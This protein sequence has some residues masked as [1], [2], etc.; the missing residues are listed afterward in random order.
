[1]I[2]DSVIDWQELSALYEQAEGLDESGREAFLAPLRAQK[3]RLLGQLE[4]MLQAR[5]RIATSTFLESL[6]RLEPAPEPAPSDLGEGSRVG[7]YRLIRP[8]GSGGMAEVWLA[9]RAD[10]AFDRQVAIKLLF[11]Q[12]TRSQREGFVARFER[13]RDILASLQ[14]PHIAGLHDAGVTSSGQPWLALE[15]VQGERITDWCDARRLDVRARIEL[16]MQVLDAVAYA[17]ANLVVHRDLKPANILVTEKGDVKLLD[18]GIAKLLDGVD[19]GAKD[20]ELT[21]HEGRPLTPQYASPEQVTGQ[22]LTTASDVYSAGV[23]LYELLSGARPVEVRQGATPAQ[24]ELA[25]IGTEPRA[26]SKRTVPAAV[27]EARATSPRALAR[28]LAGDLD[29]ITCK[30][31]EKLPASR[32]RSVEALRDDLVRWCEGRPVEATNPGAADRL[33]KF[34]RRHSLAVGGGAVVLTVG[35]I[36]SIAT[37]VNGL[38]ARSESNRATATRQFVV[39]LFKLADPENSR[40]RQLSPSE[41]LRTGASKALETL[42]HQPDVQADALRDIGRMQTYA[43][44]IV[45]ADANLRLVV[46]MLAEQGR[47]RDWL[48]AQIDLVDN[49]FHL[50]DIE[51]VTAV[52]KEIEAPVRAAN[53][54]PALQAQFWFL[55]GVA[56]RSKQEYA[57][58]TEELNTAL[59]LSVRAHGQAGLDTVDVLR[60]LADTHSEAGR[61]EIAIQILADALLRLQGNSSAGARDLL[62]VE[63]QLAIALARAGRYSGL[64]QRYRELLDRCDRDLGSA[65]DQ[66]SMFLAWLADVALRTEDR[67][68]QDRLLP[69]L[70]QAAKNASS[71]W[72]QAA[73]ATAAAHILARHGRLAATP[74]LRLQ[75]EQ[76]YASGQL[77]AHDRTQ[78]LFPLVVDAIVRGEGQEAELHAEQALSFQRSLE[79]PKRALVAKAMSLRGVARAMQGRTEAGLAD[80]R[81]ARVHL[82]AIHGRDHVLVQIY[83]C[84]EASILLATGDRIGAQSVIGEAISKIETPLRDTPL[85]ARLQALSASFSNEDRVPASALGPFFLQ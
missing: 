53:D 62:A 40:G 43:G 82:E 39:E 11:N 63:G 48:H 80:V 21:R 4:R 73:N 14:H 7:A 42:G 77:P 26:P 61:N 5:D 51:R 32:Y 18:F 52:L 78:A 33:W 20:S 22:S 85:L 35:T 24:V 6:P 46:R 75:L 16:F 47:Q 9:E 58:A 41:L 19:G 64:V 59:A 84:N 27:A 50:G 72:R 1:M 56:S 12:P 55:S 81:A 28:T 65:A 57:Q 54:D 10:G 29:A 37:V 13:E 68:E 2:R 8:I 38:R 79:T 25:I 15:V 60:E 69:R 49:A 76:I 17:H 31:L 44:E 83:R 74:A 67:T 70:E 3:H 36:L 30:A 45:D 71:P 34:Y 23:V 66:C